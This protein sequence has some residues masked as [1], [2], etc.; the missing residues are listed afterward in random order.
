MVRDFAFPELSLPWSYKGGAAGCS[1][2]SSAGLCVNLLGALAMQKVLKLVTEVVQSRTGLTAQA[3]LPA[4]MG[5][6]DLSRDRQTGVRRT[7]VLMAA[8]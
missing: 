5:Q 1:P 2:C 7:G 8:P 4:L 3:G 6:T